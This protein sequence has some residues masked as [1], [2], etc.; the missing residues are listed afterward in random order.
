MISHRCLKSLK[1]N[2]KYSRTHL[3]LSK[4]ESIV[5]KISLRQHIFDEKWASQ[6]QLKT[7]KN[8]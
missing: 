7:F 4:K 8:R 2:E 6:S 3:R 1:P 5:E